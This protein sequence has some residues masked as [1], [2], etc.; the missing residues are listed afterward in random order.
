MEQVDI[1]GNVLIVITDVNSNAEAK[2]GVS[3]V[4]AI[5]YVD[6]RSS[7]P[8]RRDRIGKLLPLASRFFD[9]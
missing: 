1:P 6:Q 4:T 8:P 5:M 2:L 7:I 3:L 9:L